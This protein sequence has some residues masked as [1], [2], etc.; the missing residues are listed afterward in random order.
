MA[1][2]TSTTGSVVWMARESG[3]KVFK[4]CQIL[5]FSNFEVNEIETTSETMYAQES[6]LTKNAEITKRKFDSNLP[7]SNLFGVAAF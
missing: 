1:I 3:K 4:N 2:P 7:L 5:N 6:C